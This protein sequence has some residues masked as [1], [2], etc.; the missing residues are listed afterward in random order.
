M[1]IVLQI[2]S[3]VDYLLCLESIVVCIIPLFIVVHLFIDML[4]STP[5]IA[6]LM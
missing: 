5:L 6:T 3:K 2:E 1:P 4:L